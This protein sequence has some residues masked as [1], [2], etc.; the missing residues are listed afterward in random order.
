MT[1]AVHRLAPHLVDADRRASGAQRRERAEGGDLGGTLGGEVLVTPLLCLTGE[2]FQHSLSHRGTES[3]PFF[4]DWLSIAQVHPEGGLPV[5]DSGCVLAVDEDGQLK[6]KTTSAVKHEGSF[7]TSLNVRSDGFRV[8]FSGNV[9]RFGRSDNLFGFDFWECLRRINAVLAHYELPPFTPGVKREEVSRGEV[10][11]IWSG[12]RVSR[13]D[14]T[15]NYEAGSADD[16]H[17]YL[18]W[19]GSQHVGRHE[20]RVLGQG[21]TVAWGGGKR[22]YWKAYI[23]HL[24]LVRHGCEDKQVIE[25]CTARGVVR[26]EG[27]LRSDALTR[28]GA[29]YLGDYESGWAMG[30]LIQA[31][32]D[33]SEVVARAEK[34][35]DDLDD[36]PKHL[37]GSAR[38]YLAGMDLQTRMSRASFYRHRNALLPYGIDIAVRNVRPFQ[39]RIRVIVLRPA[40]VPHWYQLAA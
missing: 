37:R 18:Q 25:H 1:A 31:F 6:W 22:Q 21:E 26:F 15:A 5:V 7:A 20:G 28:F 27:T 8:T 16:A 36:L 11:Y 17:A 14:L 35:T 9:S 12:A 29:A 2:T 3:V 40:E 34:C 23:K 19:L 10:R 33:H 38:D 4:V 30:Q 39:P 32:K 13:I 24:E